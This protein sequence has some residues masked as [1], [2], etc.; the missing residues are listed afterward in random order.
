MRPDL[1]KQDLAE[2]VSIG[3]LQASADASQTAS[4]S[5][6]NRIGS[7]EN[8]RQALVGSDVYLVFRP[9][10]CGNPQVHV[11]PTSVKNV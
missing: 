8:R 2:K 6:R 1:A 7:R 3:M 10:Q 9:T 4:A 5:A 11:S